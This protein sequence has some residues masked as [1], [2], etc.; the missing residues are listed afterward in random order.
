MEL[1]IDLFALNNYKFSLFFVVSHTLRLLCLKYG[2]TKRF[3]LELKQVS[4]NYCRLG[5]RIDLKL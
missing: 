3:L 2:N 5:K 1:L 4:T